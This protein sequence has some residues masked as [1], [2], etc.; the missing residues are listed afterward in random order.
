MNIELRILEFMGL[1]LLVTIQVIGLFKY[2]L[3]RLINESHP[4]KSNVRVRKDEKTLGEGRV[5]TF[6]PDSLIVLENE[7]GK[8]KSILLEDKNIR[9]EE[10]K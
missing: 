8:M 7:E 6:I 5:Y 9:I 3:P 10:V 4:L 2:I 1:M